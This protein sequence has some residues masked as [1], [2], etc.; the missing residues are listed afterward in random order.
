MLKKVL[1]GLGALLVL[2]LLIPFLIPSDT[3]RQQA[4]QTASEAIEAK[5]TIGDLGVRILPVPGVTIADVAVYDTAKTDAKSEPRA[6]V[7]SGSVTVAVMPLLSG[8]VEL[9]KIRL[10][11][12]HVRL[13]PPEKGKPAPFV[14]IDKVTGAVN[15]QGEQI[16][17][18][19]VAVAGIAVHDVAD[20]TPQVAVAS[21]TVKEI[22]AVPAK[23]EATLTGI[24][25][26]NIRLRVGE[27]AKGK[28]VH[29]VLV[30][31]ITGEVKLTAE[32]LTLPNWQAR[33][34]KGTVDVNAEMTPLEGR[35]RTLTA[36]MKAGGIRMQSLISDATG[37]KR[38]SGSLSSKLKIYAR[39]ADGDAM[40]RSL[41]VD[42]PVDLGK[43]TFYEVSLKGGASLLIPGTSSKGDIKY[44]KLNTGLKVRG[45]DIR[46]ENFSL[47]SDVLD[48]KGNVHIAADRKLDGE[49]MVSST[50]GLSGAKLMLG[51]TA[52][53]PLIYPAPSSMI[54]GAIG[55][56]VGGPAGA[57][58][59]AKVGGAVGST[60]EKIGSGIGSLFGGG[61][62][63]K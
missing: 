30:D 24:D 59:G 50:M 48:A 13:E 34:Y 18:P 14:T 26:R 31:G 53:D 6:S 45:K 29:T 56:S 28:D 11:K 5:V 7:G 10:E 41:R 58:V 12:I 52:D 27:K 21:G 61:D 2:L 62:K 57:A 60:V 25:I 63:K 22:V 40:Q 16:D 36:T 17:L 39:G 4:E 15:L 8:R 3:I 49:M 9:K 1:I 51:G 44:D 55:G 20:G 47:V 33:L 43:G 35:K 46:A 42:G 54:G 23:S 19:D 38:M 37:Q 32:K